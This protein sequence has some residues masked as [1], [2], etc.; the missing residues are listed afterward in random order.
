M[1]TSLTSCRTNQ[2]IQTKAMALLMALLQTAGDSDR[3]VLL[4]SVSHFPTHFSST[5]S[6]HSY[7]NSKACSLLWC[8][9]GLMWSFLYPELT[10]GGG[11]LFAR[12]GCHCESEP[13]LIDGMTH[14]SLSVWSA[15]TV[16]AFS[17]SV[18]FL[19][20]SLCT[21][22]VPSFSALWPFSQTL[23]VTLT[24]TLPHFY[25]RSTNPPFLSANWSWTKWGGARDACTSKWWFRHRGQSLTH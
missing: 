8:I 9:L 3:Q 11:W 20:L 17:P 19:L 5:S 6:R 7:S 24:H 2:Q 21:D 14:L 18:L 4:Q 12:A 13:L 23:F 15:Q 1:L 22:T 10:W 25:S 16:K